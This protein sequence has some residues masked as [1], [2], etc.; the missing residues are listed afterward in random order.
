MGYDFELDD[1]TS[2]VHPVHGEPGSVLS[3]DG[4]KIRAGLQSGP[5]E[6]E[7]TL[8]IDGRREPIFVASSGDVHF[9]HL[10][11]RVHRVESQNALRRAQRAA[12]PSGGA[13]EMR[14]PMPGVV[15]EVAVEEGDHV[16]T[17]QLLITIES[18]K[19]QTAIVAPHDARV[20]E[21]CLAAGASFNQGVVLVRLEPLEAAADEPDIGGKAR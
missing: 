8:E 15:V 19:L 3:I 16:A 4:E 7:Y 21:I 6:G 9:I 1:Q 20:A 18:M 5:R 10:R 13:E 14:A 17:G 12:S 11:G 2:I